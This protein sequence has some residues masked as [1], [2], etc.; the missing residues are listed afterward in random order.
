ME[1]EDRLMLTLPVAGC[2][3]HHCGQWRWLNPLS[4][5]KIRQS[6]LSP[7]AHTAEIGGMNEFLVPLV[8]I[9]WFSIL[10]VTGDISLSTRRETS[11]ILRRGR[12]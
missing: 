7:G 1:V 8:S 5:I 12:I 10:M 4:V 9:M 2:S 11:G 6:V 3:L